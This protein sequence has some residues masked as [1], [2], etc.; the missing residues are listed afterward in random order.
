MNYIKVL[1]IGS[2]FGDDQ[3]GCRVAQLLKQ[4]DLI[5]RNCSAVLIEA[6]DRPGVR[7][8]ELMRQA[9]RVYL[10]DAIQSGN[11]P[12][13]IHRFMNEQIFELN[14]MLSTHDM[15]VAQTLAL[16]RSLEELPEQII[17]YGIEI[18]SI[19]YHDELSEPIERAINET[20][21][22]L[23]RELLNTFYIF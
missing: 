17:L 21:V 9:N 23:A 6:H 3:A 7:L 14:S 11:Q 13:T 12:G 20:A 8:L 1:G 16:G 19:E 10:I 5:R 4:N 15:G 18:G 22:L 2:P